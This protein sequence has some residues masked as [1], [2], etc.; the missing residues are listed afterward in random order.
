MVVDHLNIVGVVVPHEANTE[1]GVDPY[2][3]L[4]FPVAAQ[5]FQAVPGR[6]AQV[7]E[8]FGGV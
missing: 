8:R 7:L 4:P 6:D 1:L 3:V 5:L 2:A